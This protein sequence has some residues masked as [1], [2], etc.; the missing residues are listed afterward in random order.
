[1]PFFTALRE[2]Q[3]A[4][5]RRVPRAADLAGQVGGQLALDPPDERLLRAQHVPRR[6]LGYLWWPGLPARPVRPDQEGTGAGRARL[7]CRPDLLRDQ[8]D[9]DGEQDRRPVHHHP[10]RC[11]ARRPELSQV[12]PLRADAGRRAG[13]LPGLLSARRILHVRAV[14]LADHHRLPARLPGG[15]HG[16]T[17]SRCCR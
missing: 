4:T 5:D 17:R 9:L 1:M 6:D 7:R 12:T 8:R 16:S 3:P 11:G 2:L 14:P 10:R 13:H 15:R